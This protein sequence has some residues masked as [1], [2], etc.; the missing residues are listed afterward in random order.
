MTA[1]PVPSN[2]L[3][4][5]ARSAF[6]LSWSLALLG[7]DTASRVLRREP[8]AT[9]GS[10]AALDAVRHAAEQQLD[11]TFRSLYRAGERMQTGAVDAMADWARGPLSGAERALRD[12]AGPFS[13][14]APRPAPPPPASYRPAEPFEPEAPFDP[15]DGEDRTAG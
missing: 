3:L 7:A 11:E 4:D 2:P 1:E 12:L 5:L 10:A 9:D 14:T 13:R 15:D 6:G 8:G